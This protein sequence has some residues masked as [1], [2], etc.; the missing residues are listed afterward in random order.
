MS[1]IVSLGSINLDLQSRITQWPRTGETLL[2]TDFLR[3]GGGKAA[4][5]ALF[6]KRLGCQATAVGRVGGD[7]LAEEA[8]APL[9][10]AGV[11]L[12]VTRAPGQSTAVSMI[13]VGP[14][15]EKMIV[16]ASNANDDWDEQ[17][18]SEAVAAVQT[19]DDGSILVVDMEVSPG[20]VGRALHAA[21]A[22]DFRIVVDPSPFDRVCRDALAQVDVVTPNA[23]EAEGLTRI[24]I[25]S[26]RAAEQAARAL[27]GQGARAAVV[28]LADGGCAIASGES[29]T[30]L[31][32]PRVDAVD[33]TGAGDAFVGALAVGML[34]HRSLPD[35]A[36]LGM[37]A[38]A[39][40]VGHYGSQASYPTRAQLDA[41]LA[42][43]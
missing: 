19:A 6:A 22:R 13:H 2:A 42:A 29:S 16:L 3:V 5:V 37:A 41:T 9:R 17:A 10:R 20:V 36:R 38:A 34:E 24:H 31:S 30:S 25:D 27:V 12:S 4:N 8:L 26:G 40:S 43:M 35:A 28:R 14:G 32:A 39:Y 1:Q 21:R 7:V 23:A 11:H 18:E 33:K 15:G